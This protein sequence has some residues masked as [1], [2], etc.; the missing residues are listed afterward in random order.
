MTKNLK[1]NEEATDLLFQLAV[2]QGM[3]LKETHL[4]T[5]GD[6]VNDARVRQVAMASRV[7]E[8]N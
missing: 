8:E 6:A 5:L 3:P 4:Q 1:L 7:V 2:V